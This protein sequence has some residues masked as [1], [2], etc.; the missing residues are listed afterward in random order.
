VAIITL[1]TDFGNDDPYVAI[2]KGV[3]LELNPD[4]TIVDICHN[5]RPQNIAQAAYIL[6]ATYHYFPRGTVH[7]A[8]VDP[9]VGTERQA[10]LLITHHAFFIGPDN[11]VLTYIV[12]E[13]HHEIEAIAL[14]NP[15]FWLSPLSKT[16]HGRDIFA[17]VAA[18]LS[19]GVS[20]YEF[21]DRISS[22][23]T[24][25][26]PHPKIGED[27]VLIGRV[28][29]I[30]RFGN[31]VSD[32]KREDLPGGRI[33]IEVSGHIIDDLSSSYEEEEELLAI[34]GS[35]EHLE[36]SLRN[37]SAARFLRANIGDEVKVG[38]TKTSLKG[39]MRLE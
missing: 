33:F 19:L 8:V 26:I 12:E 10:V 31:L 23:A 36:V 22:V 11:G 29:H 3:T 7:I 2:M 39:G 14:T 21:G 6:S 30:D 9:G 32:I 27:G 13:S 5:I 15:R 4:V 24:I 34:M 20:P 38:A 1:T 16:F 18:H 28:I 25:T 37:G 35:G 17:P